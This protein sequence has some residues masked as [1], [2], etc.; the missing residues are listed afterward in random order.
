MSKRAILKALLAGGL[1]TL[2]TAALT[3]H[4]ASAPH[5]AL[6]AIDVLK[7]TPVDQHALPLTALPPGQRVVVINGMRRPLQ[8]KGYAHTA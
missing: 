6:T 5:A 1:T 8:I 3:V 2:A 7:I 4:A